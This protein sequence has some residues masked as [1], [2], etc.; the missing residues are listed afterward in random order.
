MRRQFSVEEKFTVISRLESGDSNSLLA[1]EFSCAP[2]TISTIWKNAEV[3]K[4]QFQSRPEGVIRLRTSRL[5]FKPVEDALLAWFKQQ[6]ALNIPISGP[7]LQAKADHFGKLLNVENFSCS[8]SWIQRFRQRHNIVFGKISGESAAVDVNV[9]SNWLSNVWPSISA[10]YSDDQI[11]NADEAGIFFRLTPDKTLRMKNEKCSG[12]KLSK[13]RITVLVAANM[14]GSEKRRLLIIGKSKKPRCFKNVK[15]LPVTYTSNTKA[16]MTSAI[17]ED[18]LQEWDNE[19]RRKKQKIL[20]LVDNCPAHPDLQLN[21]I[22]L[23]FLPPNTTASL[24]PMDQGVIRNLKANYRKLL[25]LKIIE[26]LEQK[27]DSKI[28]TLDAILMLSKAWSSVPAST[29]ANCFRHAGFGSNS[30]VISTSDESTEGPLSTLVSD[31]FICV[32]DEV[33]TSEVQTDE[34]IVSSVLNAD[35]DDSEPLQRQ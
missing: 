4:K 11:Y 31:D 34:E 20:L 24:Q 23:V 27:V 3:I 22:K 8:A 25:V 16:W 29:I 30:A 21:F 14:T 28:T 13:E 26:N 6:R 1:K 9:C 2:S 19:L 35:E 15:S 5:Q 33:T 10:G 12:G 7:I 17:F 18:T 32:D